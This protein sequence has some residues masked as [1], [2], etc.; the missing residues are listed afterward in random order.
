VFL[1]DSSD[2]EE[3]TARSRN[4]SGGDSDGSDAPKVLLIFTKFS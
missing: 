4:K 3:N 2:E 1:E